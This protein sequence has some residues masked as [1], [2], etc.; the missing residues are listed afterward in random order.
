MVYKTSMDYHMST[1]N[2]R[3]IKSYIDSANAQQILMNYTSPFSSN[4]SAHSVIP[5]D[6]MSSLPAAYSADDQIHVSA[7]QDSVQTSGSLFAFSKK[8]VALLTVCV[9]VAIGIVYYQWTSLIYATNGAGYEARQWTETILQKYGDKLVALW[10]DGVSR[11]ADFV[12]QKSH[13][14]Q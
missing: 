12:S 7:S 3:E 8:T 6:T 14:G 9:I 11:I 1:P 13:P 2:L 4:G 10:R 5:T